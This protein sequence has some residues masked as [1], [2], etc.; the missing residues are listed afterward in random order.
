M[1]KAGAGTLLIF[2]G[3]AVCWVA[4]GWTHRPATDEEFE[5][6]YRSRY[7]AQVAAHPESWHPGRGDPADAAIVPEVDRCM[8]TFGFRVKTPCDERIPA[9]YIRS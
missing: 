2:S 6:C 5:A 1:N 8:A 4:Y 9:C 3:L 7:Q